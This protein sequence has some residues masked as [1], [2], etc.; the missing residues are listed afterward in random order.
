L[1]RLDRVVGARRLVPAAHAV[2]QERPPDRLIDA[3]AADPK[4]RGDLNR[5]APESVPDGEDGRDEKQDEIRLGP[6]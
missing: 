6:L 5:G 1:H 2:F 4:A 3:H